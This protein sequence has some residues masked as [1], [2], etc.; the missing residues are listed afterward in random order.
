GFVYLQYFAAIGN[1][2]AYFGNA[3]VKLVSARGLYIN[4]R[5]QNLLLKNVSRFGRLN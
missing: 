4:N 1:D 5:K 2:C 3:R